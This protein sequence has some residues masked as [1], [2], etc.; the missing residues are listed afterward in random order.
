MKKYK[1]KGY[2]Y[3]HQNG[4]LITAKPIKVATYSADT[5]DS[6]KEAKDEWKKDPWIEGDGVCTLTT[7][8]V[9]WEE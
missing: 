5:F 7:E 2:Y 4:C 1:F 3:T 6:L 8:I 9:E